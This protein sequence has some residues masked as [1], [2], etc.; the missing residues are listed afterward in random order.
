MTSTS[1]SAAAPRHPPSRL[2]YVAAVILFLAGIGVFVTLLFSALG[3]FDRM[4]RIV[5]PGEIDITLNETGSHT[6]FHEYR[7]SVDGRVYDVPNASGLTVT[8][9]ARGSG[10]DVPLRSSAGANY[11]GGAGAGR[12]LFSFEITEPGFYRLSATYRDGRKEPQTVLAIGHSVISD[13]VLRLLAAILSLLV[14][15]GV[16]VAMIIVVAVKR[17]RA[18]APR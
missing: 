7:S 17:R 16:A 13:F 15:L 12:S 18:L 3:S 1:S 10:A 14:G 2:W 11:S 9:N 4:I 6:I 5:V 8:L